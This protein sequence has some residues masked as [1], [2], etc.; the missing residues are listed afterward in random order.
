LSTIAF[1]LV[2]LAI[3]CYAIWLLS[4][5]SRDAGKE[6]SNASHA[7]E[8]LETRKRF[9]EEMDRPLSRGSDLVRKLRDW[10]KR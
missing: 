3:T 5:E 7:K 2:F 1:S 4:K 10:S 9:D 8:N 6:E